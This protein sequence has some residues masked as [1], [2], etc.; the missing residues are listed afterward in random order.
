MRKLRTVLM[1]TLCLALALS[2]VVPALAADAPPVSFPDLPAEGQTVSLAWDAADPS[3]P[4]RVK[5]VIDKAGHP[6]AAAVGQWQ[7]ARPGEADWTDVGGALTFPLMFSSATTRLGPPTLDVAD[8]ANDGM[9]YRVRVRYYPDASKS[10]AYTDYC[11]PVST[12]RITYPAV[13]EDDLYPEKAESDDLA[14]G[15]PLLFSRALSCPAP[16]TYDAYTEQSWD[17]GQTWYKR[18]GTEASHAW[19]AA[20]GSFPQTLNLG[21]DAPVFYPDMDGL[22]MRLVTTYT[23]PIG[24]AQGPFYSQPV[25]FHLATSAGDGAAPQGALATPTEAQPLAQADGN[26]GQVGVDPD[27]SYTLNLAAGQGVWLSLLPRTSAAGALSSPTLKVL[28]SQGALLA[29]GLNAMGLLYFTAPA[30]GVYTLRLGGRGTDRAYRLQAEREGAPDRLIPHDVALEDHGTPD[31]PLE[32]LAGS[33][34]PLTYEGVDSRYQ[35]KPAYVYQMTLPA[36]ATLLTAGDNNAWRTVLLDSQGRETLGLMAQEAGVYRLVLMAYGPAAPDITTFRFAVDP[37]SLSE[38]LFPLLAEDAPVTLAQEN[39]DGA[40]IL[41]LH[42]PQPGF[43]R[44]SV[45]LPQDSGVDDAYLLYSDLSPLDAIAREQTVHPDGSSTQ[46]F[47][48]LVPQAG[49]IPLALLGSSI[50]E[51]S[52]WRVSLELLPAGAQL[53]EGPSSVLAGSPATFT[54]A[55]TPASIYERPDLLWAFRSAGVQT[56]TLAW[57]PVS[58]SCGGQ[59]G[60]VAEDGSLTVPALAAGSY[61]LSIV[62]DLFYLEGDVWR[63]VRQWPIVQWASDAPL[64]P[65]SVTTALLTLDVTAPAPTVEPTAAPTLAPTA[66]PSGQPSATPAPGAGGSAQTGDAFP[67]VPA[68]AGVLALAALA[69]ALLLR[70][71]KA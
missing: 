27:H 9:Q 14:G 58:W 28:D 61:P 22:M 39:A 69:V 33:E 10:E 65:A 35:G 8:P 66:A 64:T 1:L 36:G 18:D 70:R 67:I 16:G 32:Y 62:S 40:N 7:A 44:V 34:L 54:V 37:D 25:T 46:T 52:P 24:E 41:R 13:T 26:M 21:C 43:A 49:D 51:G 6:N 3:I 63:P 5:L 23:P 29:E 17:G 68:A 20:E 45:D 60:S 42:A 56:P 55:P 4:V 15:Q 19:T 38:P 48:F 59:S 12:L 30:E 47:T 31:F 57:R 11:S 71:R 2:P 50:Q 53:V